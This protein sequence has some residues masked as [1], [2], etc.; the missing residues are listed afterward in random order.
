[1]R[2]FSRRLSYVSLAI[3]SGYSVARG[4]QPGYADL[5]RRIAP[6][7]VTVLA[8][9][10]SQGAAQRAADRAVQRSDP[11][12]A[13]MRAM[14]QRLLA[15]PGGGPDFAQSTEVLGSGFVV[16][17]EGLIV[18]NNHVVTHARTVRVRLSDS[19]EV[20]AEVIGADAATDIALLRVKAG[21][22]PAL[23][24]GSSKETAVGDAVIAVGNPYGLGQSVTAGIVS[25]RGRT[26]ADDPYIDFLQTDAAINRG[27]SG[28]PLLSTDGRVLG[29]TSVIF[30]PSG[31]SVGLGFAIPAETVASVIAELEAHGRVQR[32]Y[33]GVSVQEVSPAI[34]TALG[35]K[36]QGGALITAIDPMSPAQGI[37]Q[38][39]DVL[40]RIGTISVDVPQLPKIAAR[41]VPGSKVTL[42]V[43][44][45]GMPLSMPFTVG[46]LPDPPSEAL[47]AGG[48]DTWV[49]N[50]ALGL[51]DTTAEVRKALKA[52]NEPSGLIITQLR[53]AGAGALAGLRIGDL[54]THAG[55]RQL[56][57]VTDLTTVDMPSP[58]QPLLLRVLRDGSPSFVAVT[59]SE[60]R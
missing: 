57:A 28:G 6:S 14:L 50:L 46:Q 54:I 13:T 38:V 3:L 39:E 7:V 22:L 11:E 43:I 21:R 49:P 5:V 37:L 42:D 51:A 36:T 18:T 33:F 32:G 16:S 2:H 24:L 15:G 17:A 58:R 23:R 41:L 10:Q 30:S 9:E 27:N 12:T 56:M 60:A 34:A 8:E 45:G 25:A 47:L 52:D 55:S 40:V 31:G 35:V 59:G 1:M 29:V 53:A 44:R 20:P 19:R 48:P 4:A 26:L